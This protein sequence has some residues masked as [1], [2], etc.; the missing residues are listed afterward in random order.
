[1][2]LNWFLISLGSV[3]VCL[4]QCQ[5]GEFSIFPLQSVNIPE[6]MVREDDEQVS[7]SEE[8]DVA[9]NQVGT[10]LT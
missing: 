6:V 9:V 10:K 5:S 7:G 3:L 1:M 4:V 8:S 2:P